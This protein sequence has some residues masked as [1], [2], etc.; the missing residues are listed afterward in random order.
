MASKNFQNK[1]SALTG[2]ERAVEDAEAPRAASAPVDH[3]DAELV[4]CVRAKVEQVGHRL[5]AVDQALFARQFRVVADDVE[6]R[7][8][9]V[10]ALRPLFERRV[11]PRDADVRR[12]QDRRLD[13]DRRHQRR[14]R[15][16]R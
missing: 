8:R 12:R 11:G 10:D 7:S 9:V 1:T 16:R 13:A 4:L 14:R 15:L 2:F 6:T 5:A 3:L